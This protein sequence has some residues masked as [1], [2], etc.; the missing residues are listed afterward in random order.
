MEKEFEELFGNEMFELV[1]EVLSG[2]VDDHPFVKRIYYQDNSMVA[3]GECEVTGTVDFFGIEL[4]LTSGNGAGNELHYFDDSDT[5]YNEVVQD[6]VFLYV[7]MDNQFSFP[8]TEV[9]DKIQSRIEKYKFDSKTEDISK[10]FWGPDPIEVVEY[11]STDT[12]SYDSRVAAGMLSD[13]AGQFQIPTKINAPIQG[14]CGDGR[15]SHVEIKPIIKDSNKLKFRSRKKIDLN[16]N[17]TV[18]DISGGTYE[19]LIGET[20]CNYRELDVNLKSYLSI[21]DRIE[22][23]KIQSEVENFTID[24]HG[25]HKSKSFTFSNTCKVIFQSLDLDHQVNLIDIC[26]LNLEFGGI[27][28][29]PEEYIVNGEL[30]KDSSNLICVTTTHKGVTIDVINDDCNPYK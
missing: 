5:D 23:D 8:N 18:V 27:V 20:T 1:F 9:I 13:E 21:E 2:D 15:T 24:I 25:E 3:H 14:M 11:E 17:L 12:R 16:D 6:C 30:K 22:L 19:T 4:K 28:I 29:F 7:N 26:F 10:G